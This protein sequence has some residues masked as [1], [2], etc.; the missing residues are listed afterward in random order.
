MADHGHKHKSRAQGNECM[1][2]PE[3]YP[4]KQPGKI[5]RGSWLQTGSAVK[6]G[7]GFGVPESNMHG[8]T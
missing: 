6:I 1:C 2:Y 5:K 3:S 7:G 8:R 4:E